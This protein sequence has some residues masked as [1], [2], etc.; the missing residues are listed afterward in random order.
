[1]DE[2]ILPFGPI[3]IIQQAKYAALEKTLKNAANKTHRRT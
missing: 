3:Q 1:M 2:Q